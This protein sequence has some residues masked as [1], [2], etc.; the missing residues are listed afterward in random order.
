[1]RCQGV[2]VEVEAVAA[3]DRHTTRCQDQRQRMYHGVG[4]RLGARADLHH[5]HQLGDGV[6]HCPD[7]QHIR[8]VPQSG[9]QFVQLEMPQGQVAEKVGVHAFGVLPGAC[10]PSGRAS[11]R[12]HS[13][14]V[15]SECWKS[16]AA[17]AMDSPR[18]T[19]SSTCATCVAGVRSR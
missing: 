15:T 11:G 18:F 4:H 1:M 16:K 14:T 9:E 13:R 12:G 10:Q 6:A 5:G 7:P 19:A 3:E 8:F 17:S 2:E